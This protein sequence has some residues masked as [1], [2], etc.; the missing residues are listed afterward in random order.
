M[1]DS[2]VD[3]KI[4]LY[5]I[6]NDDED[7]QLITKIIKRGNSWALGPEIE[8]FEDAIKNYVGV[9]YCVSVNSGTSALHATLLAYGIGK[10]DNVVVPSFSFIATANSVAFVGARPVFAD[11]EQ[12]TF[13]LNPDSVAEKLTP[14]VRA[15]LPMDYGG[16][17]CKINEIKEIVEQNNLILIEDAAEGL[18]SSC[19]GKKVGSQ[20]DSAI[21]SF[22]G[23]K[24]LTT[25]EGGAIVTNSKEIA[26]KIK[27]IRSHGRVDKVN[28]FN[29]T[30]TSQYTGIGYNWRM[31]SFTASLGISQLHKLDKLIKMRKEHA[32]DLS[33]RLSKHKEIKTPTPLP[34]F[35]HI[36]QMY[37]IVLSNHKLRDD[38]KNFLDQKRIFSKIYFEPIH[39][40]SFYKER[41]QTRKNELPVTEEISSKILTLPLYPNMTNDEKNYIVDSVDEFFEGY[42]A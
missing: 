28:Y 21:F 36:Y 17:S 13:G 42:D 32:N 40:T 16:N 25:G 22:C 20:S 1:N 9:D 38:L 29:N 27:A 31:S 2:I 4:P 30:E 12:D 15:I 19:H 7:V 3:W 5:K 41:Y 6:Y 18:G 14:S 39:L 26:E 33:S 37:S 23:N 24:V 10:N 35:E 34:N 11:I 8:E